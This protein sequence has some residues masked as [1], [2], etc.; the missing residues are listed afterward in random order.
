[1]FTMAELTSRQ[2]EV[3]ELIQAHQQS[4]GA[5]PTIRE[6]GAGLKIG[7]NGVVGHLRALER[8][9]FLEYRPNRA[10]SLRLI[11]P[12]HSLRKHVVDVPLFG[13]IPA[14]VPDNRDQEA[15]GCVSVDI[16]TLGIPKPSARVFALRVNGDSM[17]GKHILSGDIVVLEHGREPRHGDVVAALIDGEST[18]K[19][20]VVKS[21][22]SY[23]KAENPRYPDLI[24]SD[25]LVIQGV[26]CAL[27]RKAKD[28]KSGERRS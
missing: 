27:V 20:Y 14:G 28:S 13:S 25:E 2:R 22:K 7:I 10:R 18:L 11:S 15:E 19:T 8:K 9:G 12:L 1:M 24:P 26:V 17:I 3:L 21:G 5:S 16:E 23:L 6:L 4:E